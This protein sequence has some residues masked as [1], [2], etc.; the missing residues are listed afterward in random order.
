MRGTQTGSLINSVLANAGP[1]PEVGMAATLLS[2]TDRHPATVIEVTPT[3]IV[4]QEDKAIRTDR[5][6]ISECQSYEYERDEGGNT[7]FFKRGKNRWLEARWNA[8][9]DRLNKI[10]GYGLTLGR[11]ERYYDVSF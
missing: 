2:W 1:A 6:A 8:E 9:T 10:D 3:Y 4:V 7:Y 5:N 11:R